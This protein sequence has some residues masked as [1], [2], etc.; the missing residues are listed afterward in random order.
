M[1]DNNI[2]CIH[3]K[4]FNSLEDITNLITDNNF[5]DLNPKKIYDSKKSG[6]LK[7]YFDKNTLELVAYTHIDNKKK[8]EFTENYLKYLSNMN[9]I[10]LMTRKTEKNTFE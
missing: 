10:S 6:Y 2:I 7:L 4:R 5:L 1:F 9:S 3:L 8:I